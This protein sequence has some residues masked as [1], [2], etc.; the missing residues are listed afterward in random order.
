MREGSWSSLLNLFF[1]WVSTLFASKGLA[2][3]GSYALL[4]IFLGFYYYRRYGKLVERITRRVVEGLAESLRTVW[5]EE[6][7][8]IIQRVESLKKELQSK[9]VAMV[10]LLEKP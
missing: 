2:A 1:A 8:R 10:S 9:R 3:L 6:L 7:D 5:E 4:N